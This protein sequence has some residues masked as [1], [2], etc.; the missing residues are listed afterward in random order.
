MRV[1]WAQAAADE[2]ARIAERMYRHHRG[3][4][5]R[6]TQGL[7]WCAGSLP[8]MAGRGVCVPEFPR[9]ARLGQRVYDPVRLIYRVDDDRI[10][11][12][13]IK[14]ARDPAHDHQR[15]RHHDRQ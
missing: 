10:V 5:W 14:S 6:W 12:L 13:A 11:V 4:A 8:R 3:A 15:D 7:L 9:R 1:E 2:A